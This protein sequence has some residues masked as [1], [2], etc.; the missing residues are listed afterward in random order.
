MKLE[1]V[2]AGLSLTGIEPSQVVAFG[3]NEAVRIGRRIGSGH[4]ASRR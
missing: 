1:E 3:M 2:A 4:R